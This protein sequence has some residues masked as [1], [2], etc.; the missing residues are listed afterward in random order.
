MFGHSRDP[1]HPFTDADTLVRELPNGR[2]VEATSMLEFRF[3]PERLTGELARFLDECWR[4]TE[5]RE[6]R[7]KRRAR[8]ARLS[9]PCTLACM[10]S[11]R[12]Q[13][14]ALREERMRRSRRRRGR[15]AASA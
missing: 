2:L 15:R 11:R 13:K 5:A 14:Q 12:E 10:T 7:S 4:P 6:P 8:R 9:R 3:T 1:I